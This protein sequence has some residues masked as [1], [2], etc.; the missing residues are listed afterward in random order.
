MIKCVIISRS[1]FGIRK[2]ETHIPPEITDEQI[3]KWSGR[4]ANIL[5]CNALNLMI[6]CNDVNLIYESLE[7]LT[8]ALEKNGYSRT[9]LDSF[10]KEVIEYK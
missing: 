3:F 8:E 4:Q 9:E 7:G 10:K 5:R 1:P 6:V 2:V